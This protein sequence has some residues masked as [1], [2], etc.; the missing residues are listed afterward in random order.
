MLNLGGD[1]ALTD[2]LRFDDTPN[3]SPQ[4]TGGLDLN[5]DFSDSDLME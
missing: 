4:D 1:Q 3:I 2:H 5:F